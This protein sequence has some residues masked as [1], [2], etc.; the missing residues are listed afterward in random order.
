M[1]SLLGQAALARLTLDDYA[2]QAVLSVLQAEAWVAPGWR[3]GP[4][5]VWAWPLLRWDLLLDTDALPLDGHGAVAGLA[6]QPDA[7]LALTLREE[8]SLPIDYSHHRTDLDLVAVLP[9]GGGGRT[10]LAGRLAAAESLGSEAPWWHQPT[11]GAG[12]YLRS[13]PANRWRDDRLLAAAVEVRRTLIGPLGGVLF[14]EGAVIEGLH[15]GAG[16]GLRLALPPR[17]L[18]T[19]RLDLAW[20][21]DGAGQGLQATAG[22][23][24]AF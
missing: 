7:R 15:S 6:W 12:T 13:A 10:T 2:Q 8:A 1:K 18:N 21:L 20:S 17:P 3:A 9:L 24:E 4:L 23:G 16:G 14:A 19:L 22:W 5:R 11:A